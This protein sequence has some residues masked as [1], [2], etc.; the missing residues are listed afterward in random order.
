MGRTCGKIFQVQHPSTQEPVNIT[1]LSSYKEYKI[2]GH[3]KFPS[4]SN[5]PQQNPVKDKWNTHGNFPASYHLSRREEWTYYYTM[6]LPSVTYPLESSLFTKQQLEKLE[7][8]F[9]NNMLSK[10]VIKNKIVRV[11]LDG[12]RCLG[13]HSW[14]PLYQE[15]GVG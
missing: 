7:R 5:E 10:C 6:Y 2:L 15:Q 14:W 9:L 8:K 11:V 12:L 13:R 1:V 4:G 3:Y